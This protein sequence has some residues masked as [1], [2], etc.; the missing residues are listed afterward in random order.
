MKT[1]VAQFFQHDVS[2]PKVDVTV[3]NG[4]Y[5]V[6]QQALCAGV[7]LVVAGDT[8]DKPEVTARVGWQGTE[9]ELR[10]GTPT[11]RTAFA[12]RDGVAK[13]AL[14]LDE[15]IAVRRAPITR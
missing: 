3:T 13:I 5:R 10:T 4:G 7:P 1:H 11:P 8:E 9:I 15:V 14:L 6:V 2:L 12:Q